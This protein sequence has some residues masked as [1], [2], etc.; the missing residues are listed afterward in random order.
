[1]YLERPDACTVQHTKHDCCSRSGRANGGA[2][3]GAIR[4]VHSAAH[5]KRLL[6]QVRTRCQ[7]VDVCAPR[8]IQ[9]ADLNCFP[10]EEMV[11]LDNPNLRPTSLLV[12]WSRSSLAMWASYLR[13]AT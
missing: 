13:S 2:L 11:R 6:Q 10:A 5:D 1:V 3:F 8:R 4:H 7:R 12:V 9:Q